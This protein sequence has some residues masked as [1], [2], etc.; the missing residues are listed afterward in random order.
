MK[1]KHL[2]I[3]H[4][5]RSAKTSV[6][7][8]FHLLL[9]LNWSA[10]NS[11]N[12][13]GFDFVT[14]CRYA[15]RSFCLFWN[16]YL[17]RAWVLGGDILKHCLTSNDYDVIRRLRL[18]HPQMFALRLEASPQM[19]S[20]SFASVNCL[21]FTEW[22]ALKNKMWSIYYPYPACEH[23]AILI[24][25]YYNCRHSN[26]N[27][28]MSARGPSIEDDIPW[29]NEIADWRT[30][31]NIEPRLDEGNHDSLSIICKSFIRGNHISEDDGF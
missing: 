31:P 30:S 21:R 27:Y 23:H 1:N 17:V 13:N 24:E 22:I 14:K 29:G 3:F 15:Y 5:L 9:R 6:S 7:S 11:S 25:V 12:D 2:V 28:A 4:I 20:L 19:F 10:V 18:F 26:L 16:E 8:N